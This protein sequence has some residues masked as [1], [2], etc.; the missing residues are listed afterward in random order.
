MGPV[1]FPLRRS[2]FLRGA[3]HQDLRRLPPESASPGQQLKQ[4]GRQDAGEGFSLL[5]AEQLGH[6][7]YGRLISGTQCN[8]REES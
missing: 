4:R 6:E 7:G 8:Q 2:L 5:A 1:C 3:S